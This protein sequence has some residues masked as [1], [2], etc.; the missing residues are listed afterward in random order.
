THTGAS[1]DIHNAFNSL[2]RGHLLRSLFEQPRLAPLW[3]VAHWA[4]SQPIPLVLFDSTGAP[5]HTFRAETG[6]LQGEPLSSL[7]FC[8]AI[9]PLLEAAKQVAGP[10]VKIVAVTDDVT[11]L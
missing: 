6:C 11:F 8:L 9:K 3:R 1:T 2:D 10:D 4:Y 7:L 5:L